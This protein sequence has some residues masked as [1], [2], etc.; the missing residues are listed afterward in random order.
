MDKLLTDSKKLKC[1]AAIKV[2]SIIA[3]ACAS[4]SLLINYSHA[5]WSDVIKGEFLL[6]LSSRLL[7]LA[8]YVLFVVYIANVNKGAKASVMLSIIF[9]LFILVSLINIFTYDDILQIL[10][11]ILLD[12]PPLILAF[13]A[14][15]KG[16]RN[17][18]LVII[19]IS[20]RLFFYVWSII[21]LFQTMAHFIEFDILQYYYYV[22][23]YSFISSIGSILLHV[24]F[25]LLGLN[26]GVFSK[27]DSVEV[28]RLEIE[29]V[30]KLLKEKRELDIITEEEYQAQRMEIIDR[31]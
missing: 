1:G 24:A 7:S 6:L 14:A 2:L 16:F 10:T 30:L 18:L 20:V 28:E 19:S 13:I 5:D 29:Q 26:L 25:L 4:L 15:L 23:L 17:K 27:N 9:G 12:L 22:I 3:L 31:L 21:S 8:S 11:Y